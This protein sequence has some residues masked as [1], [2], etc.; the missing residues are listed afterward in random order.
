MDEQSQ[1]MQGPPVPQ[2]QPQK[3]LRPDMGYN[4]LA[5][6]RI[7]KKIGRGQFSEVY[8]AACLLDGVPVALKKVQIFDLMDAKARA[9]CIKE[10]DL[11]KQLNHPNVIKYYASFI[12]DNELNIVLELA[13]AGDL[14]R[15]IKHFKKQKRL[16]PER[17][18]WKYFVQ[19][20]SALEHMHSRRVMHRDIKPANV[21]ITATG[22]VK[23]GDLG[24]GR[25][26]SS[27]TTAAHSLGRKYH[28][29]IHW[30]HLITCLQ[31]EYMK[32]GTTSNLTSGPLAV[33]CM[34]FIGSILQMAALQSP[35]YGDKMNLYSL[36]KK[37]E[38]CDY[39]PLPSDH[40]SEEL[41]QLVNMCINPD[42]EKRPD[43]TY[44]YDVAKRMHACMASS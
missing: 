3:A 34:S 36:C 39:P 42:P 37:I 12:E 35:F 17:T 32:M 20:C 5:N 1:G 18:V 2:F 43:I 16:I 33:Y 27:K 24:L 11:L 23:L 22:V 13:D 19:L 25:F 38:Q 9:D 26:F 15:M 21:F 40:Y 14:S 7:E 44:V 28:T 4:T 10:I 29:C 30:V 41:R 8:R 6:F 31:R